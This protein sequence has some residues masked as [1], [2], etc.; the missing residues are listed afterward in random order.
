MATR[1][2]R[3]SQVIVVAL[4][5]VLA[6]VT[7][8]VSAHAAAANENLRILVTNDDGV[9]A[10]G[11]DV[12]VEALRK[13]P[14]VEVTV[15]APA[16][17][18]TGVGDHVSPDPAS[19]Q[20]SPATT[21]SGYP[22]SAV[23]GFPGDAVVWAL[24]GGVPSR[25]DVVVS[26][27]NSGENLG[28]LMFTS[29]TVGAART[30]ARLGVPALA[31][32]QGDPKGPDY[33]SGAQRA[34]EWVKSH[35]AELLR[36]RGKTPGPLVDVDIL[37]IPTCK[38]G[39][40]R[41]LVKVP[42]A[43]TP[44]KP[45]NC[46]STARNPTDDVTAFA[47]GYASLSE[48]QSTTLCSRFADVSDPSA[49]LADPNLTEVSGVVAS[50]AHPPVLWVHNDS[51]GEP[52]VYAISPTGASLGA[53]PIE[54]ATAIDWE[55]IAIGPGPKR[56]TSSLY[57]GDIGDN[58]SARGSIVV[59][60]VAE[61]R[62]APNG[63]GETLK[64]AEKFTLRYPDGARDAESLLVDP[65]SGDLF[66][67]DKSL[68]SGVGTVYRV[69]R[70]QLVDGAN[71]TMQRVASFQVSTDGEEG[72]GLL[73]GTLITGADVSPDGSV[74]LIRTYRRVLAFAR[75]P[76]KPLA[77]AFAV[78]ACSAPQANER[79]GEAIGF[80]ADGEGYVTTSEGEHA[81]IHTF[82]AR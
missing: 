27:V 56:G 13:L 82:A 3:W 55:D 18:K 43:S 74:V 62:T 25:P 33:P 29:G 51:G 21:V 53:Y 2:P 40:I 72:A 9:A 70:R 75:P 59:Y 48:T 80:S 49:A 20:V 65:R 47:N 76:G 34:V 79:Q 23:D 77:A 69:P 36:A 81:P 26:G 78:D 6:S 71:V 52:T 42:I 39:A 17:N 41:G 30:A 15:A 35:R 10:P 5:V 46:A 24:R 63:S 45:A 4:V 60:R 44:P 37:N 22:A 58:T 61:P 38:A 7:A 12:L 28:S 19:L 68:L 66:V 8:K 73:P 11:I 67:I 50:R 1:S 32:S 16:A 54:G 64:G 31:V 14:N 57:L